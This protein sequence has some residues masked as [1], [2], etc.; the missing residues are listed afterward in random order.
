V[1][2]KAGKKLMVQSSV[3]I[4]HPREPMLV[5]YSPGVATMTPNPMLN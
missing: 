5:K 2:P 1:L 3:V 4:H